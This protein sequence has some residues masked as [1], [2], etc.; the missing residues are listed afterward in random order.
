MQTEHSKVEVH[1]VNV[2]AVTHADPA[3]CQGDLIWIGCGGEGYW[4]SQQQALDVASAIN[5]AVHTHRA[6]ARVTA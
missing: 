2:A 6:C 3:Y 4:L 1:G 5:A